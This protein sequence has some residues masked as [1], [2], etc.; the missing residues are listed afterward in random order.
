MT[1]MDATG[2]SNSMP[3]I[4]RSLEK[5]RIVLCEFA[6][7]RLEDML[8]IVCMFSEVRDLAINGDD[9]AKVV[10][11]PESYVRFHALMVRPLTG[12]PRLQ[13]CCN[14]VRVLSSTTCHVAPTLL[15]QAKRVVNYRAAEVEDFVIGV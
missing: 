1:L 3:Q 7:R 2:D 4:G 9:W 8:F 5:L 13:A 15:Y 11:N 14:A 12:R 6:S 10:L